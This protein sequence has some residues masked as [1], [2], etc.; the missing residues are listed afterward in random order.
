MKAGLLLMNKEIVAERHKRIIRELEINNKVSVA[1][2]S[3]KLSVTPETIRSDLRR[4][5]KRNK[6]RRIHGGAIYY[7]GLEKE[8]QLNKRIGIG[9]PIKKKIG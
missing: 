2:L 5:E 8:Q 9:L 6:L 1:D 4:L 3:R 7:F